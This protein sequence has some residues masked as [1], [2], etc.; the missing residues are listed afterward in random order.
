MVQ[1]VPATV[2]DHGHQV[3][4]AVRVGGVAGCV[5]EAKLQGEDDP[6][7]QFGVAVELV[8]VLKALQVEGEDHRQLLY[9]HPGGDRKV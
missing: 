7:G 2:Y 1:T 8:H 4:H 9:S 3:V 5:E 6:V